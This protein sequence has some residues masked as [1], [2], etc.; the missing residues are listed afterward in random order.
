VFLDPEA[1][2][3]K[4]TAS[5]ASIDALAKAELDRQKAPSM[6]VGVVVDGD[7][8]YA[9]GYGAADLQTGAAP[10]ADTLYRIGSITKSFT[11][12]AILALRDEGALGLDDALARYLPEAGTLVYPTRDTA[13]ITLR[14]LLTHTSGLPRMAP[15]MIGKAPTESEMVKG[16]SGLPLESP[17]GARHAY[18]NLGFA[19]LGLV[20][21]RAAH[22]NLR[23]VVGKHLLVPLGMTSTVWDKEQVPSGR[24]LATSYV[25]GAKGD[26]EKLE[27]MHAGA[28]EGAGGLFSTV[29]DMARYVAFQLAAYP[30]RDAEDKGP[31]RR[32]TVR[33]AHST[34]FRS[35]VSVRL[36]DAPAKGEPLASVSA[37]AY[38]FGWVSEQTCAFDDLVWHNGKIDGYTADIRFLPSRGVGVVTLANHAEADP[39]VLS[40]KVLRA[41]DQGGGLVKRSLPASPA[42][43]AAAK[44][45]LAVYDT[46]DDAAYAAMLSE[47]REKLANEKDELAGYK[48]LHGACKA[49]TPM[50]VDSPVHGR[51]RGDCERGTFQME[52]AISA[53]DGGILGF[54]GKSL[55]AEVP[56]HLRA[57]A[58]RLAGLVAKWDDRIYKKHLAPKSTKPKDDLAGF[59]AKLRAAHGACTVK[60]AVHEGF[61]QWFVLDCERGGD[62]TLTVTLD[63]KDED[64]VTGHWYRPAARGTCP[65]R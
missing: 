11:G 47:G 65:V 2:R 33:E 3:K 23:D 60:S 17:P 20:A 15:V 18:S 19:L 27:T 53:K 58:E 16:I 56:K 46:W 62:M 25:R 49:F 14:Q 37:T 34:G 30:P 4:L 45:L 36:E 8:A 63:R 38:G 44:K 43:E 55:D 32:S 21:G 1:R 6:V 31:I 13:P 9:K 64:V 48:A 42:L 22:Q 7:L 12:L 61:D 50:E 28:Q 26:P 54:T 29:R 52:I 5:F 10:D 59:Y 35:G 41:L 51:F 40:N 24:L 57:V 39:A